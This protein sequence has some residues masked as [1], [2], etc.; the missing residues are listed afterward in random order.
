[1]RVVGFIP[2]KLNSQRLLRKNVK[3]LG[4]RPLV[5]FVLDTLSRTQT[6]ENVI[7]ASSE[8]IEQYIE[9]SLPF[10]FVQRPAWLDEDGAK[11]QDFVGGFL[12]QVPCDVVVLLHI[13]S[14]FISVGT[15][16]A[17]IEAVTS[18]RHESAFAALEFQRFAWFRGETLN[19]SLDEPTP[20]TQDLEPV[21]VEQSGLYV[22]TRE[23]F[24]RTGRRIADH[25]YIHTV[26]QFEGHD[27][28]TAEEFELAE[29]MLL[30]GRT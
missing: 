9:T 22:F 6:D 3:P 26:D 25:P 12:S 11:V 7:Y 20:R 28:D 19:Y 15:V 23:L 10:R 14:P 24:E 16:D 27:I 1:M 8:E 2:S 13:T 4:G 18:G 29:A 5:N 21:L 17:C 30:Q